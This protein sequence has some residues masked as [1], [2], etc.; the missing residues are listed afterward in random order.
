MEDCIFCKIIKKEIPGD[1]VYEDNE[2]LAFKDI[3]P[4]API[5]IL[6]IPKKHVESILDLKEEDEELVGKI[7]TVIKKIAKEQNIEE[8]GFRVISNCGED[9]GQAVKHL[10]FHILAGKKLGLKIVLSEILNS[11]FNRQ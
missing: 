2:I 7:F 4:Q 8:T 5:H 9:A 11:S 3:N 10:H 1:I 6:V